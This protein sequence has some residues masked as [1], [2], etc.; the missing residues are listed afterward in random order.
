M[1]TTARKKILGMMKNH[2][3]SVG[4]FEDHI[5]VYHLFDIVLEWATNN[6]CYC[7]ALIILNSRPS[8]DRGPGVLDRF[9]HRRWPE[10]RPV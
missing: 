7:L 1:K 9:Q 3:N 4:T 2:P 8:T 5:L 6:S 10:K